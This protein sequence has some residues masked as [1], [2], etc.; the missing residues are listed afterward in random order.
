MTGLDKMIN[1][2]LEEADSS[3]NETLEKARQASAEILDSARAEAGKL[4]NEIAEKSKADIANFKDRMISSNDLK[5]R[6]A[7]LAAKQ[8]IIADV[9]VKAYESI[10]RKP[11]AEYFDIIRKM[12]KEYAL[13]ENGV[14]YFSDK[15]LGRLPAGFVKEAQEIAA[16]K[17]GTISVSKETRNID[18]GFVLAYGGIE[19]NCSVKALFDSR[20]D[21][22]QDK[23]QK[24]LFS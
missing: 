4:E 18:G 14:L 17:G 9:L 16:A 12:L 19:E 8:E 13:A 7:I 22:L 6:T 21:E 11:D 10:M 3:A 23:V 15:D 24:L 2:I 1:Q 20:K 5:R